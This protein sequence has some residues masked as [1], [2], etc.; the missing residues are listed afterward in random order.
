M[1]QDPKKVQFDRFSADLPEDV[2]KAVWDLLECPD[3]DRKLSP[4]NGQLKVEIDS[5]TACIRVLT[6]YDVSGVPEGADELRF[7]SLIKRRDEYRLVGEAEDYSA[8]ETK[9]FTIRFSRAEV[10]TKVCRV[11]SP[12]PDCSP[13]ET[14]VFTAFQLTEKYRIS[15]ALFNSGEMALLPLLEEMAR[16]SH[17][18]DP[19]EPGSG[20]AYPQFRKLL[21]AYGGTELLPILEKLEQSDQFP[22][23]GRCLQKLFAKLN[24]VRYEP[25]FRNIW[26]RIAASQQDYPTRAQIL[27][28]ED[29]LTDLRSRIHS[30]MKLYGYCGA[31]PDYYKNT[32]IKGIRLAESYGM[33]YFVVGEKNVISHIRV[34]EVF[35]DRMCLELICGTQVLK[36]NQERGDYLSCTFN[37]K[38]RT[39][40]KA[41]F[42]EENQLGILLPIADK[43]ARLQRLSREEKSLR[44]T[45]KSPSWL[46]FLFWLILGGGGFALLFIPLM[47]GFTAIVCLLA[48]D[49]VVLTDVPWLHSFLFCWLGYG[50]L[51]G[52]VMALINHFK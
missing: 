3:F 22:K 26:D 6:L 51:M 14:L 45:E 38:G 42:C 39:F 30:L 44:N 7:E 52:L 21:E 8:G 40:A 9:L 46:V 29:K 20:A 27:L 16:L 2:K 11:R 5:G 17:Y 48:G 47:M 13:W 33:D 28:A 4:E 43:L 32:S 23:K 49:P 19:E 34:N 37:S 36:K 24:T 31:Y 12:W 25:L 10:D 18:A 50:G 1:E 41:I 35:T 15:E